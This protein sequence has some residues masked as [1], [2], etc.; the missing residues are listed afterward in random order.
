MIRILRSTV[1]PR[2][3]FRR[4]HERWPT[5]KFQQSLASPFLQHHQMIQSGPNDS[6]D[7]PTPSS[8]SE[9]NDVESFSFPDSRDPHQH[10]LAP[11]VG[12]ATRDNEAY[13]SNKALGQKGR[14]YVRTVNENNEAEARGGRKSSNAY[15]TLTE[16]TGMIIVNDRSWVDYF[17][18]VV[19]RDKILQPLALLGL[20]NKMDIKAKIRGGGRTGQAEALRHGLSRALQNWN[21]DYRKTLKPN[22][23]LTRDGRKVEPK[24][25]G[26]KKARKSFQWVKR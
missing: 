21:P 17:P 6:I 7:T 25:F 9:S 26:K 3:L 2:L 5:N 14:I 8:R 23:L 19:Q 13:W 11:L 24:K 15:V 12:E 22:G 1:I 10:P 16:G 18:S 4:S 20:L